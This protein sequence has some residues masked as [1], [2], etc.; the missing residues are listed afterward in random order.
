MKISLQWL[1]DYLPGPLD[2]AAIAE[3]HTHGGLPVEVIDRVGD[4]T[5]IDVEV[6]SNRGDCLS[7]LG[8]AKELS[9]LLNRP[10]KVPDARPAEA[11]RPASG[12]VGVSIESLALCPHYVARVITGV[13]IGAS[14][15]W[16]V[17]RLE[18]IGLRSIN[19]V[20]DITNY[21]MFEMGQPLH[22]FDLAK[23]GGGK[24]I[25]RPAREN[26]KITSLDGHERKLTPG[27]L[28]IADAS[29]PVALAGVMGGQDSEVSAGTTSILLESARFDPLSIRKTAR[30]LAMKSDSSYRFERGIDPTLPERAS[31]RAAELILQLAGGELLAG[32]VVAGASG[33]SPKKLSLRMAKIKSVLGVEISKADAMAAL[34]RDH[35]NPV[36][37][38][39]TIDVTIPS[40]R[41]DLNIE[42]DL[43]EEV[44]RVLGYD[45]IPVRDEISIRL[46]PPDPKLAAMEVVR[47]TLVA[48]G[49]FESWTATF[50][51]DSLAGDFLPAGAKGLPRVDPIVRKADGQLRPSI[52]PGMLEAVRRNENAGTSGARL[53]ETGGA[54]W[55]DA[56]GKV[57][58]S[59]RVA[60][61]GSAGLRELRGAVETLLA[62]L[63]AKRQ[64]KIVPAPAAGFDAGA[65]GRI[66]WA[67]QPVGTI[68][69][70]DRKV[71][72]KLSLKESPA[73]A[74]LDLAA[75]IAA[76]QLVPQQSPLPRYPSVRR[77]L[78]LVVADTVRYEAID[79]VVREIK[80]ANLEEIEYVTTYRGKPLEKGS[81]S[82][83]ITL[84]FRSP[85]GTLTSEQ[86]EGAVASVVS[87]AKEKVG[88]TLR[89]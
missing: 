86:V 52:L 12:V 11:R 60:L 13:K 78:S 34:K 22:A 58:E 3:A 17:K 70:I 89:I 63:D 15:A 25:V 4:D 14:P 8:V 23:I 66:E 1:N 49:F 33:Y 19:N 62:K 61:V 7:H 31:Q 18:A 84:V 85:T 46:S 6:T 55:L 67:G 21:V 20:V 65:S 41:L 43:V 32:S 87:A 83:T 29:K 81:K 10:F 24:I 69:K 76:A 27:M 75:L 5:V 47:S 37:A 28:V 72:D 59:S 48:A 16:M 68:G 30:S 2:A 40:N 73:A 44:A 71:I 26:E 9:A 51:T 56:A 42:V 36:D 88:A 57:V 54:F 50:V 64:V 77:D 35:L 45:I 53:F 80:P 82:V 74:E 38:G 79:T 39:Q